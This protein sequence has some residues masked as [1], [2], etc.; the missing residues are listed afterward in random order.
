MTPKLDLSPIIAP[1]APHWW[2]LA[3]GWWC[4]AIA[5]IALAVIGRMLYKKYKQERKVQ[6]IA[7]TKLTE[8]PELS[9]RRGA[10]NSSPSGNE[11]LPSRS[12]RLFAGRTVVSIS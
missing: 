3:W 8:N 6:N 5:V 1:E 7:L 4:L 12:D 9:P 11:L 2:P 10:R